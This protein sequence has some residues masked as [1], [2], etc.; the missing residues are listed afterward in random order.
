[1]I[2]ILIPNNDTYKLCNIKVLGKYIKEGKELLN[3]RLGIKVNYLFFLSGEQ[4]L[5]FRKP[6]W[7]NK[8][9]RITNGINF[10]PSKLT[11]GKIGLSGFY[12]Y[13]NQNFDTWLY[14]NLLGKYQIKSFSMIVT[15]SLLLIIGRIVFNIKANYLKYS[16]AS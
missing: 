13:M 14:I 12:Y 5:A 10:A 3:F 8:R 7:S 2:E 11:D 1:M 6:I 9:H 15:K 16:I 4:N